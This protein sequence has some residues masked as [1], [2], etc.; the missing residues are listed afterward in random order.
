MTTMTVSEAR[1][2]LPAL[3]DRVLAGEEVTIT[4][5]G[6]PVAIVLRPDSVRSRRTSDVAAQARAVRDL[7]DSARST[8]LAPATLTAE[9]ADE[10]VASVRTSR[11]NR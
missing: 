5:H 6:L 3:L 2:A 7:L 11:S 10:L 9:R 4:R 1:A 8:P